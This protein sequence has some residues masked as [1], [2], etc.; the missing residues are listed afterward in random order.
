MNRL[1]IIASLTLLALPLACRPQPNRTWKGIYQEQGKNAILDL[2]GVKLIF[3]DVL[4]DKPFSGSK[5]DGKFGDV[6]V[7]GDGTSSVW[8]ALRLGERKGD[9]NLV[10]K[11]EYARGTEMINFAGWDFALTD[12]GEKLTFGHQSFDLSGGKKTIAISKTG[13]PRLL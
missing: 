5:M 8:M 7:S 3:E 11:G 13:E 2:Q 9:Q 10:F 12:N 4:S 1:V 6:Q